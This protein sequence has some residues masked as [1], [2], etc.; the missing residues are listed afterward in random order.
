MKKKLPIILIILIFTA[1]IILLLYPTVSDILSRMTSTA[2][3][4]QYQSE[5]K[6][7]EEAEMDAMIAAA[8]QYNKN[9]PEILTM[10]PFGTSSK[11]PYKEDQEYNHLLSLD[12]IIGY[13]DVPKVDIYLPVYHGTSEDTLQ[14]GV[15]HLYGSALPVGGEGSHSVVSAHRGLPAAKLFTDLDQIETGDVFYFHVLNRILAYQVDQVEVVD[16]TA[17]EHLNPV[18]EKDYMTLF[19]CTPYGVN[20]HRLLIRGVRIPYEITGADGIAEAIAPPKT[21]AVLPQW[22]TF[23]FTG[24]AAIA[25]V[26]LA[27]A[28]AVWKKRKKKG[29]ETGGN[30]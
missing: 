24:S 11:E 13:V 26:I 28:F 1:G 29:N 5:V 2:V 15:G 4:A 22:I 17:L 6:G 8:E 3:I 20:S 21:E 12:G 27:A 23:F 19:T 14:K 16:P 30:S 18:S 9:L 7:I 10:D 25:L